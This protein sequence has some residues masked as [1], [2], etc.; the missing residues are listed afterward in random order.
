M[1]FVCL[2]LRDR[3]ADAVPVQWI[4]SQHPELDKSSRKLTNTVD[5]K[6]TCFWRGD[7]LIPNVDEVKCWTDGRDWAL[8]KLRAS[9]VFTQD[10]LNIDLIFENEP[11]IDMLRPYMIGG[12]RPGDV[13]ES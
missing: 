6:N 10:P 11:G 5:R 4:Y 1:N 8:K 7:V 13:K 2:D 3:L 9:G 12:I